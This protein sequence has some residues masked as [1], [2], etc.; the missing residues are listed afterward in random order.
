M[1]GLVNRAFQSFFV[2]TYGSDQWRQV[3]QGAGLDYVE[4]ES[5]LH[6][7]DEVT[8]A[9]LGSAARHLMVGASTLLEDVGTY[10]VSHPNAEAL[11]R[12]MRFG[13]GDYVEFLHSLD[14]LP[15]RALLALPDFDVPALEL[16]EH[17]Q[18]SFSLHVTFRLE[19]VGYLVMGG[20]RALADDY[21]ALAIFDL[22]KGT[23]ETS[24]VDI[25]LIETAFS[26]GRRFELGGRQ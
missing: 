11:R 20:L 9:L 6:Y 4:F 16:F 7:D 8:I 5:M 14:E 13:G 22:R 23:G 24:I 25:T 10:L 3:M 19:G 17:T 15:G 2:D 1:H 12:L 18:A 26:E 21:G